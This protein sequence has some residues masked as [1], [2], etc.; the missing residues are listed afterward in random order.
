MHGQQSWPCRHPQSNSVGREPGVDVSRGNVRVRPAATSD[1][2]ELIALSEDNGLVDHVARR[3]RGAHRDHNTLVERYR[4]LLSDMDR[5]V[6]VAIDEATSQLV[7]FA[8]LVE[9]RVG[10]LA[11]TAALYVSHLLVAP[12]FRRRGAGRAL[13][14]GAVRHAEDREIDHLVVGVQTSARDA[15]RYLARLGFAPLVVRRIAS[16]ATLRRSLGIV[17][18]ID[19]VALRRR[20]SVRGV[21]PGRVVGRGA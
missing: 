4:A 7:G 11:P 3:G 13:L 9:E 17:E 6:L 15:N 21:L 8:V 10:V 20:R 12:S 5:L 2:N 18:S 19:R 16:V 14:T 1:I